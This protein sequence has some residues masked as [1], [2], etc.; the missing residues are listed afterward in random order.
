M[1]RAALSERGQEAGI[2]A[3]RMGKQAD[4][5]D[6]G[7]IR[8]VEIRMLEGKAEIGGSIGDVGGARD[9]IET[10]VRARMKFSTASGSSQDWTKPGRLF[11]ACVSSVRLVPGRPHS[12][13]PGS[14][15]GQ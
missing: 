13:R 10:D 15:S 5:G 8:L 3:P 7:S 2:D 9:A 1:A 11:S 4:T 14:K 6:L 12:C